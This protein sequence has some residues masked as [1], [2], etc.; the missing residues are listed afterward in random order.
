[1]MAIGS[2]DSIITI[3]NGVTLVNSPGHIRS[4]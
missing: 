3:K 2:H 4:V 1:M